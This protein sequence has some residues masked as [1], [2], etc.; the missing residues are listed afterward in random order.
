MAKERLKHTH[1][2]TQIYTY[3]DLAINPTTTT[4]IDIKTHKTP[5]KEN[6][7]SN[8]DKLGQIEIKFDQKYDKDKIC[9]NRT[10][11]NIHTNTN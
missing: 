9:K 10:T 6:N 4:M 2:D 8:K 5:Q 3:K 11:L 7:K 1:K